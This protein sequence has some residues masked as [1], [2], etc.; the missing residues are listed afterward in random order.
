MQ[1][2]I[3]KM[4]I[5]SIF[6]SCVVSMALAGTT[7]KI[8]GRVTDAATG[9]PL[10]GANVM[11]VG[12]TLGAAADAEGDYFII[13]VTPGTYEVQSTVIGYQALTLT[14]VIVRLDLT[15]RL[16]FNLTS[17]VIAGEEVTV[18]A[19]RE[20]IKMDESASAVYAGIADIESVPMMTDIRQYINLQAGIEGDMIRGGGLDQ[21][22]FMVDGLMVVDNRAN[23]PMMM[24]N[25]SS[26]KE[27]SIIKGGFNAEYGNVRSGLINVVTKEGSA[28]EY[29]GSIDFR[30]S[31]ARQ[32]HDG[33]SHFDKDNFYLRPYLDPGV[34]DVGTMNGTWD[35]EMQEQYYPFIGWDAV[36]EKIEGMDAE[37]ARNLFIWRTLAEGSEELGQKQWEYGHKPDW[38][39]DVG[40]GGPVPL[41]SKYLGN[42]SFFASYRN[43]AEMFGL[44][45]SR[46]YYK[47]E[48][49]FL[50]LTSR[51]SP[52]MK[53]TVEGLY[54][55]INSAAKGSG[56][57]MNYWLKSGDDVFYN[58]HDARKLY[59]PAVRLPFNVYRSMQGISFDHVLSPSTF[60]NV[61]VSH[62][63]LKNFCDFPGSEV[64]WR[65][66]TKI[67]QFGNHWVDEEPWGFWFL[68]GRLETEND[69]D[70]SGA[71]ANTRDWSD[72][73]TLNV[74]FDLTS[75][76][77]KY[78]QVKAGLTINYDDINS[79]YM[80]LVL[81]SPNNGWKMKWEQSPYRIGAYVQDK[82]EF[83]GMVA[84]FGL[85]LDYNDP[86]TDW[87]TVDR[88][89]QYFNIKEKDDFTEVTPKEPVTGRL[90]IS[91]RL[92]VSHPI[93]A[94]AKLYFNYGHFYSMPKSDDMYR[95]RY[96]PGTQLGVSH[97]GNPSADLPKTVAY[98]LGLEYN[99]ADL[100]LVHLSGYYKDVGDQTN[101]VSYVN[102]DR[103]VNYQTV[104]NNSY[105]DIRGFELRID[106]RWGRWITGWLNYNYMV[107]TEG[108]VGR[109]VYYEDEWDA[110]LY[111]L[112]NPYQER[113]LARPLARANVLI[114]SPNDFG[115]T[116]SRINPF[117]DIH[118]S[119][120][121][122]WK[123]GEY[124]TWDPLE[125]YELRQ[126]LQW[127][128]RYNFDARLSK[129]V[130][131][132]RYSV[133]LFADIENLFNKK[134][135]FEEGFVDG[136]DEK[137]YYES[138]HLPMYEGQDYQ[139]AGFISG[140][141]KPGDV[142]SDDKP[143]INMPNRKFLTYI[144]LRTIFFG[145]KFDF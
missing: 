70:Y 139:E 93:S 46:E 65:D 21:T 111:G 77:N 28:S 72:L 94:D 6:L 36:A 37:D 96:R 88:Y 33:L 106:K 34:R 107:T 50:K 32:K 13:N 90:K 41:V 39:V 49:L 1:K 61:R 48:N 122:S 120:L 24:V 99:I 57:G 81:Y 8:A 136:E 51:I 43:N 40:L 11:I 68:S 64:G 116:I 19:E 22:Q 67:R 4:F 16:D 2:M 20:I 58:I 15:T 95:I 47:E 89:S 52:S 75:Q 126:N 86:N 138:L 78:N 10:A 123:A 109:E 124:V 54:G 127:E 25:L 66:T 9:E 82:L 141:D 74:K 44:P 85:R 112:Q 84:N 26:I 142:K 30:I 131:F 14:E 117:G 17:T 73:N 118:L 3:R 105:A 114:A 113:P 103:S 45:V 92:G 132:G 119:V 110:R 87:Y 5:S 104:D 134:Y 140:D 23:A 79:D 97:I 12:T 108:Y 145:L 31:P 59:W 83:E 38:N 101:W 102:R 135:L 115:P 121:F 63:R 53:I 80:Q 128:G 27:L 133:T 56:G 55:E 100:F 91:P 60:Y 143:Y 35:E 69:Q 29:H 98:E 144:G 130:R 71:G 129:L 7:G 62:I 76:V 42:L 125:T 137:R 18:T